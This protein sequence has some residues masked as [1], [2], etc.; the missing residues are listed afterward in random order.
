MA[1]KLTDVQRE[2]LRSVFRHHTD[3][4]RA[5]G[6]YGS[7]VQGRSRTGSDVDIVVYGEVDGRTLAQID[8]DI[9]ASDLSIFW[10]LTA[11]AD[12]ADARL[13]DQIDHWVQPLFTRQELLVA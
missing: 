6:V 5:V 9:D 7:R 3:S 8:R 2:T 1:I 12:V 11:Y 13:K 4:I 10:N